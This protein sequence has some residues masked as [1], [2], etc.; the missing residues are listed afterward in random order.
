MSRPRPST[1]LLSVLFAGLLLL[2]F[3]LRP[4]SS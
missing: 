4:G 1:I 3:W 2:Y